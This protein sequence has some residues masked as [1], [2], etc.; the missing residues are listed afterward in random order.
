M[1]WGVD[2]HLGIH[3]YGVYESRSSISQL[4]RGIIIGWGEIEWFF[5]TVIAV[6]RGLQKGVDEIKGSYSAIIQAFAA[7]RRRLCS[8]CISH[9]CHNTRSVIH[10]PW[11]EH[12]SSNIYSAARIHQETIHP[13]RST[14]PL[15]GKSDFE[16][17]YSANIMR[18][19]IVLTL[20]LCVL[21]AAAPTFSP[22]KTPHEN[23]VAKRVRSPPHPIKKHQK[24]S[25]QK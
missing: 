16:I 24:N 18:L 2:D 14:A 23:Q 15:S 1:L 19:L 8:R 21:V 25:S 12:S 20:G 7:S 11:P 17:K 13:L 5:A 9:T 22:S 6:K 3:E 4:W 10:R